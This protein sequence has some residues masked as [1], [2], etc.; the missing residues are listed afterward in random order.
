VDMM[1]ADNLADETLKVLA[2]LARRRAAGGEA[3]ADEEREVL[4]R[5][6]QRFTVRRTKPMLNALIDRAPEIDSEFQSLLTQINLEE[7]P[8]RDQ[9]NGDIDALA[10]RFVSGHIDTLGSDH[11]PSPPDLKAG[12]N[13]FEAWGGIAGIQHGLLLVLD[14]Y[15]I[16]DPAV[17]PQLVRACAETPARQA[18]L[19]SKGRLQVGM[20]ADLFLFRQLETP[21]VI[22]KDELL[23]RQAESAYLGHQTRLSIDSVWLRGRPVVQGGRICGKPRGRFIKGRAA[24]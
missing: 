2:R 17:V 21:R 7:L 24:V 1:G 4:R 16:T 3:I 5:E 22:A 19:A 8:S 9:V 23:S 10:R 18:G 6:I 20:D 11:S 14:R 15:G 12:K 13:F